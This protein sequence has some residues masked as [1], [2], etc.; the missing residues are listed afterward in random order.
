MKDIFYRNAWLAGL[1]FFC[2]LVVQAQSERSKQWNKTYDLSPNGKVHI[3]NKYGN[4]VI[5]GWDKD[6]VKVSVAIQVR[7]RK[8]ENA[9]KTIGPDSAYGGPSR[10][11]YPIHLGDQ[12]QGRQYLCPNILVRQILLILINPM[13]K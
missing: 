4:V 1:L 11:F 10:E 3:E 12:R 5:N 8:D 7:H 13:C 6:E 2:A 9:Q